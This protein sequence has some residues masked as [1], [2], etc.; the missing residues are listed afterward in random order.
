MSTF[1]TPA[2]LTLE[3]S[4]LNQ[5]R[6]LAQRRHDFTEVAEIDLKLAELAQSIG[7]DA[8]PNGNGRKANDDMLAKVSE[9]NRKANAESVRRAEL[10]ETERKRKE[11]KLALAGNSG[12]ATPSDPSAR[13]RT[14]PRTFN[15]STSSPR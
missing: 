8:S 10:M 1:K 13:L 11:R 12:T 9:R 15:A 14:V 6:T 4:R 2:S 3:K 5:A 7:E